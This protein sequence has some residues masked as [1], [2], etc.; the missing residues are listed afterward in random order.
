MIKS[1]LNYG[2]GL[3]RNILS[4]VL[5]TA[6][7]IAGAH[8]NTQ[9][10]GRYQLSGYIDSSGER[11]FWEPRT[12]IFI[13]G[14][15]ISSE[16]YVRVFVAGTISSNG[17][18]EFDQADVVEVFDV[19]SVHVA[20]GTE[21]LPFE[22]L[23]RVALTGSLSSRDKNLLRRYA[24][25]GSVSNVDQVL[26]QRFALDGVI[27]S[28]Q[29]VLELAFVRRTD[30]PE[31]SPE[32]DIIGDVDPQPQS[33]ADGGLWQGGRTLFSRV[34]RQLRTYLRSDSINKKGT[35]S[36]SLVL[37]ANPY[38]SL[39][40]QQP[41]WSLRNQYALESGKY[42]NGNNDSFLNHELDSAFNWRM[43]KGDQLTVGVVY[44]DWNNRRTRQIIEDFNAGLVGSFSHKSLGVN[45]TWNHGI[46]QNRLSYV[47]KAGTEN[48][49]VASD[50]EDFG[51]NLDNRRFSATGYWR[52]KRRM[53]VLFDSRY[54]TFDYADRNDG[55]QYFLAPGIEIANRRRIAARV[56]AGY[57]SKETD[58]ALHKFG[59]FFWNIDLT[60]RP[61]K[62]T[63][64]AFQSARELLDVSARSAEIS[65]G[66]FGVQDYAKVQWQ[67][68]WTQKVSSDMA[69]TYQQRDFQGVSR[70]GDAYQVLIGT[71]Y[72]LSP[73]LTIRGD[74]T[75]T[76]QQAEGA[77]AYDRWTLTLSADMKL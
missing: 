72:K 47:V 48:T 56:V 5:L 39:D 29:D 62:Q 14:I 43:D 44:R 8:A 27:S 16:T 61:K 11:G 37:V 71:K 74:G 52:V 36:D 4:I 31:L 20:G 25:D 17:E 30:V 64:L 51:Y 34:D 23:R 28:E 76:N 19:V 49:R 42:V 58:N 53:T 7:S 55:S 12:R 6:L 9:T 67:Q 50:E 13:P 33:E 10:T 21:A 60:W 18:A 22:E 66:E 54:Q 57:Q 70:N 1:H 75:Y 59:G 15:V 45:G 69:F 63:T 32:A 3:F 46:R 26:A 73:G 40:L 24:L 2:P 68:D 65:D 77:S 35:R 38:F 41:R